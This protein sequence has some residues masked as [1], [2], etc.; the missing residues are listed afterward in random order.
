MSIS[1][2]VF[3]FFW[4]ALVAFSFAACLCTFGHGSAAEDAKTLS[5]AK[6]VMRAQY[7]VNKRIT[8]GLRLSV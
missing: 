2:K 8:D 7:G 1:R 3:G 5:E 6:E 4:A